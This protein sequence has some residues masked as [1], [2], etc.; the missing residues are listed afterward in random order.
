VNP[1]GRAASVDVEFL[2]AQADGDLPQ[3]TLCE[4]LAEAA[5]WV[6]GH[7][8]VTRPLLEALPNLQIISRRGVGYEPVDLEAAVSLGRVVAPRPNLSMTCGF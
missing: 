3:E 6:V 4:V 7:A 8:R 1:G 5:G 2:A